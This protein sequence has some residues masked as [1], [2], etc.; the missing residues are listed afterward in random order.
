[1]EAAPVQAPRA[2]IPGPAGLLQVALEQGGIPK[3]SDLSRT[4]LGQKAS[5]YL[6]VHDATFDADSWRNAVTAAGLDPTY[7]SASCNF[8]SA[9]ALAASKQ[10]RARRM[11]LVL[12]ELRT[13]AAGDA[14]VTLKVRFAWLT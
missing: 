9:K 13:S 8:T 7:C 5:L 3:I 2:S 6:N 4:F 1:M 14:Y 12:H 11:L 10:V